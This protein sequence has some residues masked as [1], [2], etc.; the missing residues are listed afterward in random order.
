MNRIRKVENKY[1]VLHT[2]YYENDSG[3]QRMLG[4]WNDGNLKG[5]KIYTFD[6]S[7]DAMAFAF[8]MPDIDWTKLVLDHKHNFI[9]Y[10]DIIKKNINIGKFIVDYDPILMSPEKT[11]IAIFERVSRLGRRF[12]LAYSMNDI[13]TYNICNPWSQ[14]LKELARILSND[15]QLN[16]ISSTETNGAITLVGKTDINTS[17]Q[18]NLWPT[19][20]GQWAKWAESHPELSPKIIADTYKEA[21]VNQKKVDDSN[22]L[23]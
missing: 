16:I 9:K 1:Q 7:N 19:L 4:G 2:P 15:Q 13:I 17:Y 22:V 12:T 8:E 6:N 21:V 14:N 23:R 20:I 11:K 10:R 3:Y 5:Y 18:I